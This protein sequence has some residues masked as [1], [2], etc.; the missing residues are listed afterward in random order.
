MLMRVLCLVGGFILGIAPPACA[1]RG[2]PAVQFE[3]ESIDAMV[4]AFMKE[5]RIPGMTLAIVQAPY[6]SRVVGYGVADV[7][8]GLLASPKTLWNIGQMTQAYTAVAIMQLVEADK[9]TLDDPVGRHLANLPP[10]W[11][12]ITVRQLLAHTSGLPDYTKQAAFQPAREYKPQ[13][14]I[15]L[16]K[17]AALA[18]QPGTA[19]ANS[20][21]DFFLLGLIVERASGTSYE[22][23]VTKN[24]IERLGLKN[25]LFISDRSR[26]KSEAVGAGGFKH[27]QFLRDRSYIDPAE[28]A[29]GYTE[30]DGKLSPVPRNSQGA[31]YANGALLASAEDISL[32]DIGLAGS[33]LVS[34]KENRNFLYRAVQLNDGTLVPAHCGWRF[35]GRPGLMDIRGNVPGF[36]CYL[37]RLTVDLVCVT[38]CTNKEGVDLTELGRRIAGA[39]DHKLGPPVGPQVM[40]CRES[41]YPV[42]T[43]VDRLAAFLQSKGVEV[44]ARIDHAAAAR[45]KELELR[46]TEVLIFGNPA[47]GTHLMLS[48]PSVALELPLRVVVWQEADGT[49]WAGYQDVARVARQHGIADRAETVA[50]IEATLRAALDHATAP[51]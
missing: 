17:E 12:R 20:A 3:G 27:Q 25:T 33:I 45:K 38:L 43:T 34:K 44:A 21:T 31:W 22:A 37:S 15:A 24:Q 42:G 5:H 1:Q 18:F 19:V 36:S 48:R 30:K 47:V 8:T 4:A 14:I 9:L 49:V 50:A 51:Y 41:C 32:W 40:R 46:P 23:Y 16:V 11:N 6:I 35:A 10:A 28:P 2:N 7:E 13:E 26:L 29:T 39:F